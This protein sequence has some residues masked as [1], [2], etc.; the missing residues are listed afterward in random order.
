M[1]REDAAPIPSPTLSS[2]VALFGADEHRR[3]GATLVQFAW[4]FSEP[5][6]FAAELVC[7]AELTA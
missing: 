1:L 4:R 3:D 2:W 5:P 7:S 6:P